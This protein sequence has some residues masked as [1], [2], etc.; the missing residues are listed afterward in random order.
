M[1]NC[2]GITELQHLIA[3][4]RTELRYERRF[5]ESLKAP[6]NPFGA[7]VEDYPISAR[8][9]AKLPQFGKKCLPG[10]FFPGHALIAGGI[11]KGDFLIV[12]IQELENLDASKINPRRLNAKEVLITQRKEEFVFLVADGTAKL[13]GSDYEF[14]ESTPRREQAGSRENLKGDSQGEP[15]ES[16]RAESRDDAEA[17]KDF[18]SIQGDFFY[19]HHI[20]PRVQ[21]YVPKEENISHSTEIHRRHES[22][23]HRCGQSTRKKY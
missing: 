11:W 1:K 8:D 5:G 10:F 20:E 3:L 9:Q 17:R 21:L 2:C 6:K 14:Q 18:L 4:R 15:E 13:S 22:N 7:M 19:G 23:S 16:Q 12:D